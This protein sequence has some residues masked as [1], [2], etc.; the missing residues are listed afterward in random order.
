VVNLYQ[1]VLILHSDEYG[2]KAA[3][4]G[5]LTWNSVRHIILNIKWKF[6]SGT[7]PAFSSH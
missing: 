6:G 1:Q 7:W 2:R 4:C 5:C 3:G